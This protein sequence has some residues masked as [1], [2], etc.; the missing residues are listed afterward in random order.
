M[1]TIRGTWSYEVRIRLMNWFA[2]KLGDDA[3]PFCYL[4]ETKFI[5]PILVLASLSPK[6]F[7]L[8]ES[9]DWLAAG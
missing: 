5:L 1:T 7:P 8:Q 4:T 6:K 2:L 9:D 3:K